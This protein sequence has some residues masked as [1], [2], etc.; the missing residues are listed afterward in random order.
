[1]F[2]YLPSAL[3]DGAAAPKLST[4]LTPKLLVNSPADFPYRAASGATPWDPRTGPRA[5]VFHPKSV[6]SQL[7]IRFYGNKQT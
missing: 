6:R 1:M 5:A 7:K 4:M 2:A 3:L